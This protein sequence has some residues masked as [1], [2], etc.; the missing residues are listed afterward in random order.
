M[1][2]IPS[3]AVL[4]TGALLVAACVQIALLTLLVGRSRRRRPQRYVPL[5]QILQPEEDEQP[6]QH[7]APDDVQAKARW[8]GEMLRRFD[9]GGR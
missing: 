3:F 2:V 8:K 9:A 4:S 1:E 6:V 5:P 7:A